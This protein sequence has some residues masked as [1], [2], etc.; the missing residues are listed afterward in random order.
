MPDLVTAPLLT[1]E[2]QGDLLRVRRFPEDALEFYMA[3]LR[4]GG[5]SA[6][7]MNKVGLIQ[8]EL[9]NVVLAQGYFREAIKVDRNNGQG[10]NNLA[11]TEYLERQYGA[12]V[13]DY[14]KAVKLSK[15]NAVFHANLSTAYFE[16]KNYK[17]ARR[18]ADEAL[19]LDPLV[20]Q[21]TNGAGISAHVLT[22]EDRARFAYEMAKLYAQHG[23]EEEMLHSLAIASENGF[24]IVSKMTKDPVLAKYKDDPRV[25]LLVMTAKALH[26]GDPSVIANTAA[27][28]RKM[29][30]ASTQPH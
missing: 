15:T 25:A 10:W 11:A 22:V 17:N 24:D 28:N 12:S 18:E 9:R 23:Q 27:V 8:L 2:A 5:P 26:L 21:H 29:L 14:K 30:D 19:R 13:S 3:A 7:L 1:L 16:T 4:R 6:N 20:Y